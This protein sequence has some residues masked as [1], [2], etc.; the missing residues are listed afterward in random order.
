MAAGGPQS[1]KPAGKGPAGSGGHDRGQADDPEVAQ[2]FRSAGCR[3][4]SGG[5]RGEVQANPTHVA[6]LEQIQHEGPAACGYADQ[7]WT[8]AGPPTRSGN[9]SGSSTPGADA[10]AAALGRMECAGPGPGGPRNGQGSVAVWR[11]ETW[12]S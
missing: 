10:C 8:L 2:R 4:T 9:G 7:C 11:Q 12:L 1:S 3:R 6:E 5:A